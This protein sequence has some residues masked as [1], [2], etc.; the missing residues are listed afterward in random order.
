M[1]DAWSAIEEARLTY[2]RHN[3]H[4][5]TDEEEE[6]FVGTIEGDEE[7]VENVRLPSSFV[8]SPA[9]SA[10]NI[11]DCLALRKAL[12]PVTLFITFTTNPRWPEITS[13]LQPGQSANDRPDLIV[14]VFQQYLSAFMKDIRDFFGPLLYYIRVTEFQKRGL[15]HEHIAVALK[16]VPQ[17]PA[18]IDK[19]LHAELPRASGPLREA[20]KRHMTHIHDPSKTYHRCGWP[21][22]CQYGFP[23]PRKSESSFNERGMWIINDFNYMLILLPGYFEHCRREEEDASI[24]SHIPWLIL[25]YDCHINVEFSTGVQLFQYLFKYFFKPLDYANWRVSHDLPM[26]TSSGR[27]R[28]PVDEIRDYERGRYLS[29]IEAATRLASFHISQKSPGV[30][31]LPIHLPGR[32]HG[33]MA[34]KNDSQSDATLLVRYLA[35]PKHPDLDNLTYVEF[36]SKCRLESH[37]PNKEMHDLDVLEDLY[38]DRPQMRIR[39]YQPGHVGVC[40]IQMVY[41]RHGDVFY[42][43]ALLLHRKARDWVDIRTVDGK[44]YGTYQEA[45]RALGLFDNTDEGIM[46]FKELVEFGAPPAQLRWLFSV[47]AIEGSPVL[48]IWENHEDSLSADIKDKLLRTTSSPS[49]GLIRNEVLLSL[50][51]LLQGLGKSLVEIGLPEPV[52]QQQEVDTERLRWNGDPTNLC[53]FKDGLTWEQVIVHFLTLFSFSENTVASS[54]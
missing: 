46:A 23:K 51:N 20:V 5:N 28:K 21:K 31:R 44:I 39:F 50:Q 27:T 29:S 30:K 11:S 52:E 18:E 1:V 34:R 4:S 36:G 16:N 8:H 25:K 19:F 2:I 45:A 24:V 13:Q 32:H 43:R 49:P 17:T 10:A 37:D 53:A 48:T 9:W 47:L 38:P 3:Q 14:R 41:P 33:Q 22:H 35:R 42:L 15:P 7:P 6:E 40:R 26:D 12:G 54:I